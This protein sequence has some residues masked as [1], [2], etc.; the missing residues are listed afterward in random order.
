MRVTEQGAGPG[1]TN[2]ARHTREKRETAMKRRM[3]RIVWAL[4]LAAA[5]GMVWGMDDEGGSSDGVGLSQVERDAVV[6]EMRGA[7]AEVILARELGVL[8]GAVADF[9]DV[10]RATA[11]G[12]GPSSACMAGDRG[13]QG[14]HYAKDA[15][16]EPSVV[17]EAP[18]LLMYEPQADGS[19]RFLGV[20][21]LVFQEAWHDAGHVER[22]T[23]LGQTFGLNETLLDEPFY[24]LHVW[25]GQ[26]NPSGV[27]ADWNPLVDCGHTTAQG[28]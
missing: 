15:L 5:L 16:L 17:L 10:E 6:V 11:A 19:L 12:Y 13:A 22:P 18:Q 26:F 9:A 24:L 7:Q 1:S 4:A 21:Y 20:E 3:Q 2:S 28:H 23:L 27:F 25:V 14:I 8:H